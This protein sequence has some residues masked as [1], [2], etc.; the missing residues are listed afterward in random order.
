MKIQYL[1]VI[2]IVIILPI[3]LITSYYIDQQ[4][5][6][7]TM[8]GDYDTKLM[9]STR[10][11][12]QAYEINTVQLNGNFSSVA[13]SKRRDVNASMNYFMK[14]LANKMGIG[15][16]SK[17][18][19][20][21][22]VPAAAFTLYD[23]YYIYAPTS[24]NTVQTYQTTDPTGPNYDPTGTK[25]GQFL[26][27]ANGEPQPS[28]E[29]Y[30]D[31]LRPFENYSARYVVGSTDITVDYTLDNYI[32]V[33][34]NING[35]WQSRA[36]YLT[37]VS[38]ITPPANGSIS[39][40]IYNGQAITGEGLSENIAYSE[41]G[42]TTY[43]VGNFP[44]IYSTKGKAYKDSSSNLF[45][46]DPKGGKSLLGTINNQNKDIPT[47]ISYAAFRE[48]SVLTA[49]N[50]YMSY[51]QLLNPGDSQY[52]WYTKEANGIYK[53]SA[54][55][56][57]GVYVLS[58]FFQDYSAVNYYIESYAFTNW[59][60]DPVNNLIN[61][62]ASS[63]CDDK[64]NPDPAFTGDTS[65][66]FNISAQN[67]NNPSPEIEGYKDAPFTKHKN[68]VIRQLLTNNIRQAMYN[69]TAN[70]GTYDFKMPQLSEDEWSLIENNVS[71]VTFMQ[72]V[73]IG[74]KYYTGYAVATSTKNN[75]FVDVNNIYFTFAGDKYYH[76]LYCDKLSA[77]GSV[78]KG[79]KS[80]DFSARSYSNTDAGGNIT[81]GVYFLHAAKDSSGNFIS[82]LADYFCII[83]SSNYK[84]RQCK[85]YQ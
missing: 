9:Q 13:S 74:T 53:L 56:P 48:V 31:I 14:S 55:S 2:F 16:T 8:Q 36:G 82:G 25:A 77:Q 60:T 66:I 43:K 29:Q 15:G 11:S 4:I 63:K 61:I 39:G 26:P 12:I 23:G 35:K 34:G 83:D 54:N 51:Y 75:D 44:Y 30:S 65:K 32:S 22:Y 18:L 20:Q 49:K 24:T 3:I 27:D 38:K 33:H 37:D 42:G 69:Y 68:A 5:D 10:E 80:V 79:Y 40:L 46:L 45:L 28:G 52:K 81:T 70:G 85:S 67:K 41:D 1:A 17:S 84:P 62:P 21:T 19:I 59:V 64:G 78:V 72:G 6:T 73:P 50:A 47:S 76:R 7:M 57:A 71:M 58:I